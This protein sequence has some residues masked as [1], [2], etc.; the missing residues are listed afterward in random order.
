MAQKLTDNWQ[1][2]NILTD[3]WPLQSFFFCICSPHS[4]PNIKTVLYSS[5]QYCEQ[6]KI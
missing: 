6:N 4:P 5:S 3:N 2:D 1:I